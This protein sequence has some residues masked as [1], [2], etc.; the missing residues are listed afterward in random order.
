MH[1]IDAPYHVNNMFS[2]GDPAQGAEATDVSAAWLN[3]VQEELVAVILAA[4]IA[5]AKGNSAQLLAALQALFAAAGHNHNLAYAALGHN[6]DGA[7]A[8]LGHN[9]NGVYLP[10]AGQA[11]DAAKLVG[12]TYYHSLFSIHTEGADIIL[13]SLILPPGWAAL[14][15]QNGVYNITHNLGTTNYIPQVTPTYAGSLVG[16]FTAYV[17][18]YANFC[19]IRATSQNSFVDIGFSL[20]IA[21]P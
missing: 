17:E 20:T 15:V 1:R 7:Y 8:A 19:I 18:R 4:G 6:H 5:L 10:I 3:A 14:R 13:D 21:K 16:D 9:H 11:A 2:E 12:Y